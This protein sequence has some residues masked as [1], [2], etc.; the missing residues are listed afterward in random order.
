[1]KLAQKMTPLARRAVAILLDK[2]KDDSN[3]RVKKG[4]GLRKERRDFPHKP[5]ERV[6]KFVL[7]YMDAFGYL[8]NELANWS[9]ITKED[10]TN[11]ITV[12]Q[13][14]FGLEATGNV[15]IKTVRAMELKRCGCP[16]IVRPWHVEQIRMKA[17][18]DANL[19]RWQKTG[20]RYLVTEYLP[21]ITAFNF[22]A[23]VAYATNHWSEYANVDIT[24]C[25]TADHP[26][27]IIGCGEGPQSNFDGPGGVLAWSEMPD[28]LAFKDRTLHVMLDKAEPWVMDPHERGTLLCNVLCHEIGHTLGLSH[29]TVPSALMAPYYDPSVAEPRENDDLRRI[30]A[31][32]GARKKV[33]APAVTIS[34][35]GDV[36]IEVLRNGKPLTCP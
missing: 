31:R 33:I 1:M 7:S 15:C 20:L 14:M 22:D 21:N 5:D 4:Q 34:I 8:V 25:E 23:A 12:F 28:T 16:D 11:A 32:Y 29:S 3:T 6:A 26:D 17:F 27:I 2:M 35:D 13:E 24:P 36:P 18:A 19:C 9:T 30:Q 10:I